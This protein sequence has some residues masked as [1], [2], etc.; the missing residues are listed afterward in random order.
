MGRC[1]V[2]PGSS[3]DREAHS[4][5]EIPLL[6]PKFYLTGTPS[7]PPFPIVSLPR[8]T[9]IEPKVI[10]SHTSFLKLTYLVILNPLII[11]IVFLWILKYFLTPVFS[12]KTS[13]YM[14]KRYRNLKVF[15]IHRTKYNWRK[16][17][18]QLWK[19]AKLILICALMQINSY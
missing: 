17:T 9:C 10:I 5:A 1:W 4:I 2:F 8:Y 18:K 19:R 6:L 7:L 3:L 16:T 12:T 13:N 15:S 11:F 14:W